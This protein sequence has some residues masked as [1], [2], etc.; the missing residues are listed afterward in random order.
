MKIIENG[1]RSTESYPSKALN[2]QAAGLGSF[3]RPVLHQEDF[4]GA[5]H[6]AVAPQLAVGLSRHVAPRAL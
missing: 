6:T 2:R 5:Q 4:P 1:P 3:A